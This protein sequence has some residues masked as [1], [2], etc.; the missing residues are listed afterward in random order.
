MVFPKCI[1]FCVKCLN[2]NCVTTLREISSPKDNWVVI[3]ILVWK[4]QSFLKIQTK[5]NSRPSMQWP[6]LN[7]INLSLIHSLAIFVIASLPSTHGENW[8]RHWRGQWFCL[9]TRLRLTPSGKPELWQALQPDQL[10]NSPG[11]FSLEP[12][13]TQQSFEMGRSSRSIHPVE[14]HCCTKTKSLQMMIWP[15]QGRKLKVY[16]LQIIFSLP[17]YEH[18]LQG[19]YV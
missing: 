1:Y 5:Q 8:A 18:Q 3:C 16:Q 13:W 12:N 9:L 2:R 7:N 14:G 10:E 15:P 4:V 11:F 17:R 6:G 19:V